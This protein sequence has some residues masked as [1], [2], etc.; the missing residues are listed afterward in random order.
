MVKP[1][2]DLDR[3][4]K[5]SGFCM[6][7]TDGETCNTCP[8]NELEPKRCAGAVFESIKMRICNLKGETHDC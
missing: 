3:C 5:K 2:K 6:Y 7:F 1:P 4:I 8:I